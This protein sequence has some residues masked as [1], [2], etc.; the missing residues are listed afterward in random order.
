LVREDE[1][2]GRVA[3]AFEATST[4]TGALRIHQPEN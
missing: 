1:I 2:R 3:G 4:L